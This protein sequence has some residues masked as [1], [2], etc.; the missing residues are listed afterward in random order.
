MTTGI[1][2][3]V[4]ASEYFSLPGVSITRLKEIRRS[5]QHYRWL[6]DHPRDTK[7]MRLGTA[8]HTAVLEPER[9]AREFA[10]WGER[11]SKGKLRRRS[12]KHWEQ[13]HEGAEGLTVITA[14]EEKAALDIQAAVRNN[15]IAANYLESGDPEVTMQWM[16][17]R[18]EC[19]GRVDWLRLTNPVIVGLKTARDCRHYAFSNAV[20]RLGYDCQWAWY[21]SGYKT[22]TGREPRLVEI[23]VE[24]TP[25][26]AV[27]VY[28]IGYDIIERG[29]EENER[30]L[31]RLDECESMGYFPGVQEEEEWLTLPSWYMQESDDLG[32]LDLEQ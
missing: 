32:G 19:R 11:D 8:A 28:G 13:W 18:R 2:S 26:Y 21:Y 30:L 17:D 29:M 27:A 10:V 3:R 20:A 1:R 9:F 12:G 15:P 14:D 7:A 16:L 24:N 31:K 22:I 5:P 25:P 4:P 23:V 6:L